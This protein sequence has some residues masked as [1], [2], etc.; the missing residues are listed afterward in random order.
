LLW[1]AEGQG[2]ERWAHTSLVCSILANAN[3]D[4]KKRRKPY[5]PDDFNPYSETM[6][7]DYV[8]VNKDNI[9]LMKEAFTGRKG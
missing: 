8:V 7:E 1:L 4:P 6:R 3:R 2:R 9:G 5:K